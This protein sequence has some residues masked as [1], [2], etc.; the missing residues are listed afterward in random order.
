MLR[1]P[2]THGCD[3]V[4]HPTPWGGCNTTGTYV[5]ISP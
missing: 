1:R 5:R 2:V 4:K 3:N